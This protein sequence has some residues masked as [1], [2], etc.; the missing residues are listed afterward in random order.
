MQLLQLSVPSMSTMRRSASRQKQPVIERRA[1]FVYRLSSF[2]LYPNDSV[3]LSEEFRAYGHIWQLRVLPHGVDED[4]LVGCESFAE[5]KCVAVHLINKSQRSAYVKYTFSLLHPHDSSATH[6]WDDGP[7]LF[8]GSSSADNIWGCDD[9]M[10]RKDVLQH[11]YRDTLIIR[12]S[13]DLIEVD[14]LR[15]EDLM[16]S[17]SNSAVVEEETMLDVQQ[18]HTRLP[19]MRLLTDDTRQQDRLIQLR[20]SRM[21]PAGRLP[22]RSSTS[23]R[24]LLSTASQEKQQQ[25]HDTMRLDSVRST[26]SNTSRQLI[27]ADSNGSMISRQVATDTVTSSGGL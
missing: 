15:M 25:D 13:I 8:R 7:L 23:L 20:L 21:Q 6:S 2:S 17:V 16:D 5:S 10:P 3:C 11:I 12:A 18:L 14:E 4:N 27:R 22:R 9:F 19:K 1:V 26:S 24:R